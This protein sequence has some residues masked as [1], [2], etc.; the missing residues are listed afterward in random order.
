MQNTGTYLISLKTSTTRCCTV[1]FLQHTETSSSHLNSTGGLSIR[2]AHVCT[3]RWGLPGE[4]ESPRRT[5]CGSTQG[6]MDLRRSPQRGRVGR[7]RDTQ[8]SGEG[9]PWNVDQSVFCVFAAS[10]RAWREEGTP[11]L[12]TAS[13]GHLSWSLALVCLQGKRREAGKSL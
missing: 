10:S 9:G 1:E 11:R 7:E 8:R 5:G 12:M 2:L 6:S 3:P 4:A 13:Q